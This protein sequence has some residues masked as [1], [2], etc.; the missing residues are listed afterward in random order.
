[1]PGTV[2]W[3]HSD[4]RL[5]KSMQKETKI[6]RLDLIETLNEL[7]Q[8][9]WKIS[10]NLYDMPCDQ[11][12]I[13]QSNRINAMCIK[14]QMIGRPEIERERRIGTLFQRWLETYV[15]GFSTAHTWKRLCMCVFRF[16]SWPTNRF[17]L[18]DAVHYYMVVRAHQN[19]EFGIFFFYILAVGFLYFVGNFHL[20]KFSLYQQVNK[21]AITFDCV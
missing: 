10:W 9:H 13:M 8:I 11:S 2:H 19:H 5:R 4:S 7:I 14:M 12:C 18:I 6:L 15:R 17:Q 16:K 21:Q 3:T 1:M 20:H